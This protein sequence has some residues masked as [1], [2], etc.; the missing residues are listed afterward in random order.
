LSRRALCWLFLVAVAVR[1]LYVSAGLEVP[2]QDTPDYDE[3]ANNLLSG[4]GFVSHENWFGHPMRSWRA[5][6]YPL[7]LAAVYGIFGHSHLAVQIVQAIL[8]AA[9]AVLVC[10]LAMRLRSEIA[11]LAGW[12]A[13]IYP[14]L[15][16]TASEVM[17]ES[18]FTLL[19]VAAVLTT[20]EARGRNDQRWALAAGVLVGLAGLVRPVGLLTAPAVLAVAA[21]E[22]RAEMAVRPRRWAPF[23]AAFSLGVAAALLP[24]TARNALVHGAFVPVSTH[25]GFIVARSNADLPDWRQEKGWQIDQRVFETVPSEVERDRRWLRQGLRWIAAHPVDY[26]RLVA[27]RFL[28]LWYVFEPGYNI[29]FALLLPWVAAG[30]YRWATAP[31]FRYLGALCALS[32]A[33]FCLILYGSTRFRLPLEPFFLIYGVSAVAAAWRHW[34]RPALVVAAGW[35]TLNGVIWWHDE[36]VRDVVIGA[37]DAGGLR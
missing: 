7:F 32:V 3:I 15:V 28:R 37:L 25:G 17:T 11:P 20:L 4:A 14:P 6:L 19:L 5:P 35:V 8:G 10:L 31:G 22:E 33:V 21:W 27:E 29:G 24:W 2:A 9:T 1:L 26:A 16:A 23:A 30:L 36:A 18:L 13:A 12:A 34:G